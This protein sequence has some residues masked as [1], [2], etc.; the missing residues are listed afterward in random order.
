[1][2]NARKILALLDAGILSGNWMDEVVAITTR[3]AS[4]E[5]GTDLNDEIDVVV[6]AVLA[7]AGVRDAINPVTDTA[8]EA[9]EITMYEGQRGMAV[10][11]DARAV[12]KNGEASTWLSAVGRPTADQ[13]MNNDTLNRA[14]HPLPQRWARRMLNLWLEVEPQV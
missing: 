1:M 7:P 2:V 8:L 3:G 12:K 14:M 5:D 11:A 10:T 6:D 4:A 9:G 13:L